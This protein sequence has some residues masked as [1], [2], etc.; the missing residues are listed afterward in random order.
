MGNIIVI[1]GTSNAGKTTLCEN[2]KKVLQILL[3][4]QEQT[5]LQKCI[6]KNIQKIHQSL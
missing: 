2:I 6:K 3:L 5:F 4:F 1:D